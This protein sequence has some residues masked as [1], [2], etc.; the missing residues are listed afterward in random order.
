MMRRLRLPGF[1]LSIA[2]F[3][4]CGHPA[5]SQSRALPDLYN[6]ITAAY[7]AGRLEEAEK[8][9]RSLLQAHSEELRALSL[10]GVVLDALKRYDD[11]EAYYRRAQ[12]LA[13][14]SAL[15]EN[16]LGNHYLIQGKLDKARQAFL[17]AVALDPRHSNAHFQL[18][19]I[20]IQKKEYTAALRHLD[21]M[22]AMGPETPSLQLLRAQ[23]LFGNGQIEQAQALLTQL[24]S[25]SSGNMQITFLL[26]MAY[27][28]M[29]RFSDAEKS[30][31]RVLQADPT[32]F[33]VLYNLGT[34]ALR[35][36]HWERAGEIYQ[37]ALQ[38]RP[39]DV[40][41]LMGL[42]RS[43]VEG[44]K[45]EQALPVLVKSHQLA[46]ARPD[47][48]LLMAQ[49]SSKLGFHSDA[50]IAY[51]KYLFLKPGDDM[52]RRE[53]GVALVMS[54]KL[55]EG[56]HEL[57]WYVRKYPK[58]A[59]GHYQLASALSLENKKQAIEQIN[60]ALQLDPQ[61]KGARFARGVL[62]LELHQPKDAITDL[63]AFL[64]QDPENVK[65]QDQ[66]G[67]AFLQNNEPLLAAEILKK[68][69]DQSPENAALYFQYSRALRALGRTQEL[70][71]VLDKI[72]QLGGLGGKVI[73]PAGQPDLFT[74]SPAERQA[75]DF[76][77]LQK[78]IQ[79]S[80][81]DPEP[82]LRLAAFYLEQ[83]KIKEALLLMEQIRQLSPDLRILFRCGRLLVDYKLYSNALPFLENVIQKGIV[84]EE[85]LL[86]HALVVF[87]VS[88]GESGLRALDAIPPSQRS[89]DYYLL[90]AQIL[91]QLDKFAEAVDALNQAFRTAPTRED[92]YSQACGFLIKHKKYGECL[93]LLEQAEHHVPDSPHLMLIHAIVLHL[94]NQSY[95][96]A[97]QPAK[98]QYQSADATQ[99]LIKIESQ[100]PEWYLPYLIHGIL[101]ES[102]H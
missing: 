83:K 98:I 13:P 87:H 35:A 22:T 45:E 80:P 49:A 90:R 5:S 20:Q 33:E 76:R 37:I 53:R 89:G 93:K 19:K 78:E 18:V 66:L 56:I 64:I 77:N 21:Q 3:F 102:R 79:R 67:R 73:P 23:A 60:S 17:R 34:A 8:Q 52:A 46:T 36:G 63:E 84:D 59:W 58:D 10:M 25:Q 100:R 47:I 16:N 27:V 97:H 71:A 30:F 69:I 26:G 88:G 41:C 101:L 32:N 85:I 94:L 92:L 70:D 65:A 48:L 7:Q 2:V 42:A 44:G 51:E 81:A 95:E 39:E 96:A 14:N 74:L 68:A 40:D 11:A 75:R 24:E 12:K 29:E 55:Q 6:Q 99:E 38:K 62:H 50:V 57:E 9:L 43:L 82:K 86:D 54:Q 91:D 72:S 28:E 4:F 15:I 61:L 31:A 1:L